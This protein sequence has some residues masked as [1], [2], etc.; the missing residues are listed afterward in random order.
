MYGTSDDSVTKN[1]QQY[2]ANGQLETSG[3]ESGTNRKS[4]E[5][6]RNKIK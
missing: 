5:K 2:Q 4:T 1:S 3:K 6:L